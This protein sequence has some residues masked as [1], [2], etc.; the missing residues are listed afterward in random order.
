MTEYAAVFCS[1]PTDQAFT[2][3]VNNFLSKMLQRDPNRRFSA[4]ELLQHD[5]LRSI[6][7]RQNSVAWL[8]RNPTPL[9]VLCQSVYNN[10]SQILQDKQ[11]EADAFDNLYQSDSSVDYSATATLTSTLPVT[12]QARTPNGTFLLVKGGNTGFFTETDESFAARP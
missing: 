9:S 7:G 5:F 11:K 4:D 1:L 8:E 3:D 6:I 10:V 2:A 12:S